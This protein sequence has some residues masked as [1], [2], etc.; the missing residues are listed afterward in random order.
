MR[1]LLSVVSTVSADASSSF[2]Y[3]R[4][5]GE[6]EEKLKSE[7]FRTLAIFR[8]GVLLTERPGES[9]WGPHTHTHKR[10]S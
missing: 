2:H 9:R 6:I 7:H 5:K 1:A 8:P 10:A 3:L 4:T